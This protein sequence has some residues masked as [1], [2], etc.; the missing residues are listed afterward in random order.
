MKFLSILALIFITL[1]LTSLIAWSWWLVLLPIYGP[2]ALL[3]GV[4][5]TVTVFGVCILGFS[6]TKKA[7]MEGIQKGRDDWT[8]WG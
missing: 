1:K 6:D 5:I 8:P 4:L 7:V 2:V 3:A